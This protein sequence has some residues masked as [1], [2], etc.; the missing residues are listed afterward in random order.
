MTWRLLSWRLFPH[1]VLSMWITTYSTN[2]YFQIWLDS[3]LWKPSQKVP[4]PTPQHTHTFALRGSFLNFRAHYIP[5]TFFPMTPSKQDRFEISYLHLCWF[6]NYTFKFILTQAYSHQHSYSESEV[7]K[8]GRKK[9][10][11]ILKIS[12]PPHNLANGYH[13]LNQVVH[14]SLLTQNID[15]K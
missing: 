11:P 6:T 7:P 9:G 12:K 14:V 3:S 4:S 2:S 1:A 5:F 10:F 15:G 13:K 8:C